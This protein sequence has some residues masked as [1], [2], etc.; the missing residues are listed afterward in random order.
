[1]QRSPIIFSVDV[2]DWG[3]SVLD[4]SLPISGYCADNVLRMLDL[5]SHDADA[6]GTFF[7]LGKFARKHPRVVRDIAAA[8]H[9][10]ASHGFGHVPL[11]RLDPE[12]FR[13]DVRRSSAV[14]ADILGQQ[15]QGYRAPQFS[16]V[17]STLWALRVLAEEGLAF[18]SS[19]FPFAG[20][21]YGIDD[22][23]VETRQVRLGGGLSIVEFPLT[24][25]AL[26]G[27]RLPISGGGYARL[28]PGTLLAHLFKREVARRSSWPVFY[29]HPHELDPDEFRRHAPVPTWGTKPIGWRMRWHQGLGRRGFAAKLA[30]MLKHFHFRSFAQARRGQ[31]S[32]AETWLV[33]HRPPGLPRLP[34]TPA[35]PNGSPTP[36]RGPSLM[37]R[38]A[39]VTGG[40]SPWQDDSSGQVSARESV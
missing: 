24:T 39:E 35:M 20:R 27:R 3:Q 9:E 11:H 5:L 14:L 34:R 37:G 23:P 10:V 1:M 29:C 2:E 12:R 8:G 19:I 16:I 26:A 40:G 36:A 21:R 6:R 33:D 25:F 17:R 13:S 18:D 22:W 32:A 7:V 31:P 28:L 4:Q 15:V 38:A 30:T